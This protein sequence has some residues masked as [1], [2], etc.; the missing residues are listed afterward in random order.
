MGLPTSLGWAG[1][2]QEARLLQFPYPHLKHTHPSNKQLSLS[3]MI[4]IQSGHHVLTLN[5]S[6]A[7]ASGW[8]QWGPHGGGETR[9]CK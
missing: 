4:I 7:Q 8:T 9:I 2:G 6:S 1:L 5:F 3:I